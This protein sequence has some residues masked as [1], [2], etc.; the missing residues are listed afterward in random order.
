[1]PLFAIFCL[2]NSISARLPFIFSFSFSMSRVS[3]PLSLSRSVMVF[4][5]CAMESLQLSISFA[6]SAPFILS[7]ESSALISPRRVFSLSC[8]LCEVVSSASFSSIFLSTSASSLSVLSRSA[9]AC[10]AFSRSSFSREVLSASVFSQ[11]SFSPLTRFISISMRRQSALR[12]F[13]LSFTPSISADSLLASFES[14]SFSPAASARSV[15][16]LTRFSSRSFI[17]FFRVSMPVL[18][19]TLP[20]VYEPPALTT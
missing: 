15:S 14:L 7:S 16:S 6:V 20:P 9:S 18:F 8:S 13:M 3:L 11:A 1:M 5:S 2:M 17:S 10:A 19:D 4:S 12:E